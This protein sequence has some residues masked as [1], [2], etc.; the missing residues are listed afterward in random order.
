MDRP[1]GQ[2]G[3]EQPDDVPVYGERVRPGDG[4]VLLWRP[5]PGP[6]DKPV[7]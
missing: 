1:C 7:D 2:C 3:I 6:Q 5:V 4:A